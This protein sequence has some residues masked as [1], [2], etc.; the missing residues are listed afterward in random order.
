MFAVSG[1]HE[2]KLRALRAGGVL[3]LAL[4]VFLTWRLARRV[5]PDAPLAAFS[6]A[7]TFFLWPGVVVRVG[8]FSNAALELALG[9]A[10]SLALWRALTERSDRWLLA[11]GR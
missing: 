9:V 4:A 10:L 7:L 5:V 6:F 2:T 11:R 1:D 3:L 8:T